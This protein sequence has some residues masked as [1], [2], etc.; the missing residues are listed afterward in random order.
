MCGICGIIGSPKAEAKNAVQRMMDRIRHRG[1]DGAG[2]WQSEHEKVT[3]GH[4]RLAIVDTSNSGTQPMHLGHLHQVVNGEIYNYPELRSAMGP[5]THFLSNCDVEVI[6]HGLMALGEDYISQLN[7]MFALAVYDARKHRLLLARDR[8]GIKPLY[9]TIWNDTFLFASEIKSLF[10]AI[11]AKEWPIDIQGLSEFLTYQTPLAD[12]TLFSGIRQVPPGAILTVDCDN[13]EKMTLRQFW[14]SS[15]SADQNMSFDA[16]CE[17]FQDTFRASVKRHLQ[18]D[19]PVSSYVSAGFDSSSVFAAANKISMA[20]NVGP[21]TGFTG[22]FDAGNDWYDETGPAAKLAQHLGAE[23]SVVPITAEDLVENLD[24]VIHAL[25]EPRMGMGAFSQYMVAK[26]VAQTHKVVLTGHGGDE[27]FSGYPVFAIA[28]SGLLG[29]KRFSELPHFVY[30]FLSKLRQHISPEHGCFMPVI[31]TRCSQSKL[32]GVGQADLD[33]ALEIKSLSYHASG[34][35][36]RVFNTYL[37]VYLPGLLVVEDKISMAHSLESRTP[38]LDN[39]MI[40]L[41]EAIPFDVKLNDGQL[42]SIIKRHSKALLPQT[43]FEQPKRGFPTPIRHWLRNELKHL[44]TNRLGSGNNHLAAVLNP[45]ITNAFVQGYLS[46][47]KQ[48][49]RPLDEIQSFRMWQL[50]SLE[51]W[52]RTWESRYGLTLKLA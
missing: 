5:R 47:W 51:S 52:L 29:M 6:L 7:G 3:L 30:F 8:V 44:V 11:S 36:R 49:I 16:A 37:N 18:S 42:K 1:P 32:L 46:S 45:D 27:L 23:H 2:I 21:I 31:W 24:N 9:Y 43:F 25:D 22:S 40:A 41:S 34:E 13:P 33:P 38:F 28:Q 39:E 10:G 17:A 50:L 20:A 35:A 26:S 48:R 15:H 12:R 4:R 19:V 14:Q